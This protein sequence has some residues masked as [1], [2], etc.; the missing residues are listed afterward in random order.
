MQHIY[1]YVCIGHPAPPGGGA[2]GAAATRPGRAQ[3]LER[4]PVGA[5]VRCCSRFHTILSLASLLA[6]KIPAVAGL[7]LGCGRREGGRWRDA[8]SST[9]DVT[10][11]VQLSRGLLRS[12]FPAGWRSFREE[13]TQ[14]LR[15]VSGYC[16]RRM[17]P[18]YLKRSRLTC[19]ERGVHWALLSTSE[20]GILLI[21]E[22]LIR[23][24]LRNV[25][26]CHESSLALVAFVSHE[27]W[28][29]YRSVG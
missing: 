19:E 25:L 28:R 3:A 24:T 23:S 21:I 10:L 2:A 7:V 5:W 26:A 16:L 18:K 8:C 27:W 29:A 11:R 9:S 17:C 20:F 4:P 1:I 6:Y 22:A 14:T 12:L 13:S 15:M